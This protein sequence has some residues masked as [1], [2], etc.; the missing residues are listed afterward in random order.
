MTEPIMHNNEQIMLSRVADSL[1]WVARYLERAENT[2]RLL[3]VHLNFMLEASEEL[4][5][6]RL[7]DLRK[8]LSADEQMLDCTAEE[9]FDILT[10]NTETPFSIISNMTNARENAR[11]A[12]E[13]ISSE[14][15]QQINKLYLY[16]RNKGSFSLWN[17]APHDFY[18]RVREGSHLFQGVTDATMN[19]NQSWHFIQIGRYLERSLNLVQLLRAQFEDIP[20][21]L[22]ESTVPDQYFDLVATLKSV[23][24]FEAYTK[25]YNPNPQ[26]RWIVSFLLFNQQFPRSLRFCID[27]IQRSILVLSDTTGRGK[28]TRLH[29]VMGRVASNLSFD[30]MNDVRELSP[31][32]DNIQHQIYTIHDMLYDTFITYPIESEL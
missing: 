20:L 16:C 10:F 27:M 9:C 23:S 11:Q 19:H 30:D 1:L 7:A 21:T 14:M 25:V 24:A 17:D 12:R 6:K 29:R 18:L 22:Q 15:W 31:Y 2:A 28:D 32:L 8:S 26:P 3:D 5:E 4:A 13:Q